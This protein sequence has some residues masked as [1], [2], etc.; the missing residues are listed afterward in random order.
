MLYYGLRS[1]RIL[2]FKGTFKK[3]TQE[4]KLPA[5]TAAF[6]T[7]RREIDCGSYVSSQLCHPA[8][9]VQLFLFTH[10]CSSLSATHKRLIKATSFS[11]FHSAWLSKKTPALHTLALVCVFSAQKALQRN[12]LA[13]F[14]VASLAQIPVIPPACL[15]PGCLFLELCRDFL[16]FLTV[17]V[18]LLQ[19]LA[20]C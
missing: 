2:Y 1:L 7:Y 3:F 6:K 16:P 8:H 13:R 17:A 15:V 18:S 11:C 4:R 9:L 14:P 5:T 10:L 12:R 20:F 19:P